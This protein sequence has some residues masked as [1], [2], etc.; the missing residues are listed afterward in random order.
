MVYLLNRSDFE[1]GE[2]FA[3]HSLQAGKDHKSGSLYA[4]NDA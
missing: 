4:K 1:L 3:Q 2:I